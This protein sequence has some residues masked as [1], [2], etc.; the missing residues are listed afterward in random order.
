MATARF[1]RTEPRHNPLDILEEL[2]S[3]NEWRFDR[4]ADEEMVVELP[5]RWCDFRMFFVWHEDL[6]AVYFSCTFDLRVPATPVDNG[7]RAAVGVT[8]PQWRN[9]E[10]RSL[11]DERSASGE[12]G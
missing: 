12:G 9:R 1:E 10:A 8:F 3:A 4:N 11:A 2:V 6:E 5:G 7:S